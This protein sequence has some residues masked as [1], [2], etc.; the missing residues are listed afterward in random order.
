[1]MDMDSPSSIT[2]WGLEVSA[3]V[4]AGPGASAQVSGTGPF[5]D[6]A[7]GGGL[8]VV[9]GVG[10]GISGMLTYTWY[11]GA[12]NINELSDEILNMIQPYLDT[13]CK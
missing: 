12:F 3:F 6:G 9:G 7:A 5:G 13:P 1:V 4:A 8:G 2:G 10:G 11:Q